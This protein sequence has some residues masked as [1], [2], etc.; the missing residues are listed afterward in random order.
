MDGLKRWNWTVQKDEN[1]FDPWPSTMV[2]KTVHYRPEQSTLP[3][4]TVEF[5]S[6]PSTFF[7]GPYNMEP[8][9]HRTANRRVRCSLVRTVRTEQCEQRTV[10]TVH[11]VR[12]VRTANSANSSFFQNR[13]TGRTVRTGANT[14][15]WSLMEPI[16]YGLYVRISEMFKLDWRQFYFKWLK[17]MS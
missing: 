3:E 14:V 1:Y 17:W 4:M 8:R 12:T 15:R 7:Y 6:R 2:Q 10:R 13:R 16:F 11:I 5:G 9:V